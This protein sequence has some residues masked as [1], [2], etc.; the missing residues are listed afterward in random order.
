ME[1]VIA[2]CGLSCTGCDA[3]PPNRNK[4]TTK[5][6]KAAAEKWSKLYGHGRTIKPEEMNCDGCLSEGGVL[7]SHCSNCEIRKCGIER[8]MKNCAYCRDYPCEKLNEIFIL[9]PTA[10]ANLEEIRKSR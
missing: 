6:R 4:M 7:W 9:A 10:K 5:E 2:F 8:R 3:F 1:K